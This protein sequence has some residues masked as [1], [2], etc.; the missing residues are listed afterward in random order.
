M[1]VI[2]FIGLVVVGLVIFYNWSKKDVPADVVKTEQD[3]SA[4]APYKLEANKEFDQRIWE[5]SVAKVEPPKA[6][7]LV[8]PVVAEGTVNIT[9]A[10]APKK[11]A[12]KKPAAPKKPAA[13]KATGAKKPAA[14]KKS[15]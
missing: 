4:K 3:D 2:I 10:P 5:Q 6:E 7:T 8:E 9:A 14:K 11:K 1:E 13:K 15:A 12:A